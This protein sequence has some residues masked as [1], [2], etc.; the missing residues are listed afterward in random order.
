MSVTST[1]DGSVQWQL[2]ACLSH[3]H[4]SSSS[5][6]IGRVGKAHVGT[7]VW[8][9]SGGV[10]GILLVPSSPLPNSLYFSHL[11]SFW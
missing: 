2:Q 4:S 9:W 10:W 8:P 7:P 5:D 6:G 11:T 1:R 3:R